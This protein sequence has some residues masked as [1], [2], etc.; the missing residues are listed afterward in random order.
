MILNAERINIFSSR[1]LGLGYAAKGHAL[2]LAG[3]LFLPGRLT[4]MLKPI[5]YKSV[6]GLAIS[7]GLS[8]VLLERVFDLLA[9]ALLFFVAIV[10][11]PEEQAQHLYH[12]KSVVLV[13]I[14]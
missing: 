6:K 5:Y 4:E 12:A 13:I 8:V 11:L 14:L 10:S 1:R 7:E 2:A 9:V 3:A